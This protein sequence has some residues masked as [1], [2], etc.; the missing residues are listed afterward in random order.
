MARVVEEAAPAYGQ[1]LHWET[2]YS[3]D[4]MGAQRVLALS[5]ALGRPAPIP[6]IFIGGE[7]VFETTPGVEELKACLDRYLAGKV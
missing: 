5:R 4:M 2:V 3:K 7:L 6:S 1:S